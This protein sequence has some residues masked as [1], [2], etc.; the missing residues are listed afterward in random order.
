MKYWKDEKDKVPTGKS[1]L[2]DAE[3]ET[4]KRT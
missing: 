4:L 3:L 1:S 2:L